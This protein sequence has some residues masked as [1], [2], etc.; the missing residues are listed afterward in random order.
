MTE[1]SKVY[2]VN[3]IFLKRIK[4]I[5]LETTIETKK[6]VEESDVVNAVLYKFLDQI[7]VSDVKE[8]RREIKGKDD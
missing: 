4:K 3:P 8:Y 7:S 6:K 5:W 1:E 2:R